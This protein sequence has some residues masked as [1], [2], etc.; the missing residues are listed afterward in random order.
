MVEDSHLLLIH[1][2]DRGYS[3]WDE[4]EANYQDRHDEVITQKDFLR[5]R[6]VNSRSMTRCSLFIPDTI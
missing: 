5:R 6:V 1:L 2:V 4:A 3:S